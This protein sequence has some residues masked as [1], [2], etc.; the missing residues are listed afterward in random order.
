M[1]Y[2]TLKRPNSNIKYR[3]MNDRPQDT[4][5]GVLDWTSGFSGQ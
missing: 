4:R 3:T 5:D 1:P 2:Q